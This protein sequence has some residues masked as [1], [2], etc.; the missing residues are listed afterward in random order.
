MS[1]ENVAPKSLI[2][3][4]PTCQSKSVGLAAFT[5]L[6]PHC[7]NNVCRKPLHPSNARHV[8]RHTLA[9]MARVNN[10]L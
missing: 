2:F 10:T 9:S 8:G 3:K 7:P 5:T 4:D 6:P 1:V